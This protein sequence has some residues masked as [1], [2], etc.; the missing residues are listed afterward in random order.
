[1]EKLEN[2]IKYSTLFS[3]Y[4]SLFSKKQHDYLSLYFEENVSFSEIALM[5]DVTRQTIFDNIRRGCKQLDIYEG[6]L[7]LYEKDTALLGKL[8][9]LKRDLTIENVE[10]VIA[11][12]EEEE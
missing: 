6:K 2:F 1:M 5:Y 7:G 4:K 8:N 11:F 10:K 3:Y 12:L 9:D